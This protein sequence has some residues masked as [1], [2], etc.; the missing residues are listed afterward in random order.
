MMVKKFASL[1]DLPFEAE[2]ANAS[3]TKQLF[4]ACSNL[5]IVSKEIALVMLMIASRR[6]PKH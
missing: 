1:P 3:R 5:T 4:L 2:D 6:K